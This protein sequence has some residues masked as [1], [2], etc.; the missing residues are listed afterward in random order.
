M[1]R[2]V[3]MLLWVGLLLCIFSL[4][5]GGKTEAMVGPVSHMAVAGGDIIA[6]TLSGEETTAPKTFMIKGEKPRLVFDFFECGFAG[7][8]SIAIDDGNLVQGIRVGFHTK[9]QQKV[10]LV[11]DLVT[12]QRITWTKEFPAGKNV[13]IV[14]I[15]PAEHSVLPA[16]LPAAAGRQ[17]TNGQLNTPTSNKAA[18]GEATPP[19]VQHPLQLGANLS[20]VKV[21]PSPVLQLEKGAAVKKVVPD[22]AA[23]QVLPDEGVHPL[24]EKGAPPPVEEAASAMASVLTNISFDNAF[25]QSGEMILL[26]L[27]D[28]QPPVISTHEKNP[29]Q[30]FCDFSGTTVGENVP[31]ELDASG[32]YVKRIRIVGDAEKVRV[33]LDLVPGGNYDLQQVYFKEDN[34]FVLIVNPFTE[35]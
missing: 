7:S 21:G 18:T 4:A 17:T 3:V 26:Q 32:K 15:M 33:T 20:K 27:S 13:M 16:P 31:T 5:Y 8:T 23:P 19:S 2:S 14:S 1:R 12:D 6:I 10:R 24:E 28:F 30:V 35:G 22:I 9:P 29:P 11:V 34:L 25:S